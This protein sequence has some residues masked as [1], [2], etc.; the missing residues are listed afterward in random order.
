MIPGRT[1]RC[2]ADN[3]IAAEVSASLDLAISIEY[4][5]AIVER[6]ASGRR[7]NRARWRGSAYT[8]GDV[9]AV[10]G[11]TPPPVDTLS[12]GHA[13]APRMQKNVK[14]PTTGALERLEEIK[15]AAVKLFY[16][17]GYEGTDLRLIANE[18]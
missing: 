2:A 18:L 4:A 17:R 5:F 10:R 13:G 12:A 11:A 14:A 15:A 7:A 6:D 8:A 16:Q 1:P 9:V 3:G